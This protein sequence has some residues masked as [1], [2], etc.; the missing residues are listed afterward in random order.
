MDHFNHVVDVIVEIET[1]LRHRH[2]A[3]VGPVGDVDVMRWQ[4]GFHCTAQQRRIVSG[5]RRHD[6]HARMRRPQRLRE[7]AFE[8][9]EAAE[10]LFPDRL[11]FDRNPHAVHFGIVQTPFGFAIA[12]CGAF[13]Q[14]ASGGDRFSELRRAERIERVLEPQLRHVGHGPRRI[15][16]GLAHLIHPVHRRGQRRADLGR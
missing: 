14:L 7:L 1:A 15:E 6:K 9:Q 3:R 4:E 13:E 11:D 10:R 5:H 16:R 12:T 2:H 8:M